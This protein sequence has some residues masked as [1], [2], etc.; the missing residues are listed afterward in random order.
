VSNA[1][2]GV[3]AGAVLGLGLAYAG[4]R[5]EEVAELLVPLVLDTD[6]SMEVRAAWGRLL[7]LAG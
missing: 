1:D 5:R 2:A 6:C 7:P 3:R 4:T